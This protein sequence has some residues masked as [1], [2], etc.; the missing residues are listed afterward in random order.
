MRALEPVTVDKTQATSSIATPSHLEYNKWIMQ[1]RFRLK[2][3]QPQA[4]SLANHPPG[5]IDCA[6]WLANHPPAGLD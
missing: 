3:V 5:S 6:V 1:G 4:V 2:N